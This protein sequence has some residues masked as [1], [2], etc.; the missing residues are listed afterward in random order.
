MRA[1]CLLPALEAGAVKQQKGKDVSLVTNFLISGLDS[2]RGDVKYLFHLNTWIYFLKS[3]F[4]LVSREIKALAH[5]LL[6][7]N[8]G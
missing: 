5:T 4:S 8:K 7:T 6:N 2:T 1:V 3:T